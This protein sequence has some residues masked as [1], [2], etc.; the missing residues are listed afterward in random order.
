MIYPEFAEIYDYD[1][2]TSVRILTRD[3][4]LDGGTM[5]PGLQLPLAELFEDESGPEDDASA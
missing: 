2:L 4:T 3:Q 5:L 1:S